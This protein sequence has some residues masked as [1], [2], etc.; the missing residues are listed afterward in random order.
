MK[1]NQKIYSSPPLHPKFVTKNQGKEQN[2]I[3][4][5]IL[6]SNLSKFA[7]LTI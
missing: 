4:N 6:M 7:S 5:H 3:I 1:T 2:I